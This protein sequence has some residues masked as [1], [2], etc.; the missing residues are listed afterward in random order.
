MPN[1]K[2]EGR[3]VTTGPYR[4]IRHPM[5]TSFLFGAL[6]LAWTEGHLPAWLAWCWCCPP[7]RCSKSAG[8]AR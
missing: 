6:A 3:L 1:P 5:Y 2:A 7:N 4:W 8:Y